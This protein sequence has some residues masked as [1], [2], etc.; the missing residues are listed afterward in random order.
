[1]KTVAPVYVK[2]AEV[3]EAA[4]V[5]IQ[6][7]FWTQGFLARDVT[8][9]PVSASSPQATCWCAIG[10]LNAVCR[11]SP[12]WRSLQHAALERLRSEVISTT[13]WTGVSSW[14]DTKGR[15]PEQVAE[16]M[17]RTADNI[18]SES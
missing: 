5:V 12:R 10:V 11:S 9:E 13:E 17:W 15:T 6:G 1:M 3:L 8:Q 7:G 18:R 16:L 2:A 14:N 4:A